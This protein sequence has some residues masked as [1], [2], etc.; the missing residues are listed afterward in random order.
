MN[1]DFNRLVDTHLKVED[2]SPAFGLLTNNIVNNVKDEQLIREEI[3]KSG[4]IDKLTNK[5]Q[6]IHTENSSKYEYSSTPKTEPAAIKRR[7]DNILKVTIVKGRAFIGLNFVETTG[8]IQIHSSFGHSRNVSPKVMCQV[9]PKI[10]HDIKFQLPLKDVN[11]LLDIDH[12]IHVVVTQSDINMNLTTI[13]VASIEWRVVLSGRVSQLI[14]LK[15]PSNPEITTGVLDVILDLNLDY[16]LR[17]DQIEFHLSQIISK[18]TKLESEF[19]SLAK[20]WWNDYLQIRASHNTRLV[21]VFSNNEFGKREQITNF[22]FPISCR[23]IETPRHA[24]RFVSLID[25][26]P[27]SNIGESRYFITD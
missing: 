26:V 21:K 6:Q 19:Y 20:Q 4:L 7:P 14:E 3:T 16:Y 2:I 25:N 8:T 24:S 17:K 12:K 10:N 27:L 18:K 23:W 5:I 9:E 13:G 22:I 11:N 15:D 1:L